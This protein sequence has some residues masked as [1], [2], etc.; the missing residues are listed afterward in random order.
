MKQNWRVIIR[1]IYK[2]KAWLSPDGSKMCPEIHYTQ[3][4][5]PVMA[6]E[7]IMILLYTVLLNNW[8]TIQVDYMLAFP[9]E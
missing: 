2:N 3:T 8:K 7:S 9:Q 4:Y 6:W 5:A 1:E